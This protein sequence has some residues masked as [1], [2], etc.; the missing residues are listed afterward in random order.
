MAT[1]RE[2]QVASEMFAAALAMGR[3]VTA[4]L[5]NEINATAL[6]QCAVEREIAEKTAIRE[7]TTKF[8]FP[9]RHCPK[10]NGTGFIPAYAHI[11]GG[12]CYRCKGKKWVK[13]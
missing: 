4:D 7:A 10:C 6:A 5:I 2:Q 12:S 13:A 3:E 11:A 9:V 1:D 8:G